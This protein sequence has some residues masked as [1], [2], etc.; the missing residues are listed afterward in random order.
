LSNN[1]YQKTQ[2]DSAL[3]YA[4]QMLGAVQG[5]FPPPQ[6]PLMLSC[7]FWKK[8]WGDIYQSGSIIW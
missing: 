4:A 8:S 3:I 5:H 6:R 2:A 7:K 1:N